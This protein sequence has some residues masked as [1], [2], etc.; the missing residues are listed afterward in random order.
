[1]PRHDL[2][3]S[4]TVSRTAFAFRESFSIP[5]QWVVPDSKP[6]PADELY[7]PDFLTQRDAVALR[8]IIQATPHG[9]SLG[10]R[11]PK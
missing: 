5:P 10:R 1:M 7:D 3:R 2:L 8:Q 4:A 11:T 9:I 6:A